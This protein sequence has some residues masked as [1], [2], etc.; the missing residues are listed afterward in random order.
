MDVLAYSGG[1]LIT[2]T[3]LEGERTTVFDDMR[4]LPSLLAFKARGAAERA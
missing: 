1:G 3:A 4:D 2:E